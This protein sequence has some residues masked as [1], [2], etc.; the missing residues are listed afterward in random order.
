M[1]KIIKINLKAKSS[2]STVIKADIIFGQICWSVIH[3]KGEDQLKYFLNCFQNN[4]PFI[5]SDGFI[6]GY[7]PKPIIPTNRIEKLSKK[8]KSIKIDEA[9]KLKKLKLIKTKD[10]IN[11]CN[12]RMDNTD[13][14]IDSEYSSFLNIEKQTIRNNIKNKEN[15]LFSQKEIW[16]NSEYSF[17]IKIINKD[18]FD[19]FLIEKYIYQIFEIYGYGAKTSIGKGF[20]DVKIEDFNHFDNLSGDYGILLSHCILN[21]EEKNL[22][23]DSYYKIELKY[24]K[25]GKSKSLSNNPFKKPLIQIKP[26]S[27]IKTNKEYV[28]GMIN[29]IDSQKEVLDYNYGMLIPLSKDL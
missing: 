20:F 4:P 23:K 3:D 22:L 18:I 6:D 19:S 9:K 21:R 17:F 25:L 16:T 10:F 24:G 5:I 26:G 12:R 14:L 8:E 27:V 7:L 1:K 15:G 29:L 11:I 2:F 13:E 28:G